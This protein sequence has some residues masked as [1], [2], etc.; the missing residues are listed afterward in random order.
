MSEPFNH[1]T[2]LLPLLSLTQHLY[3]LQ[4][5]VMRKETPLFAFKCVTE[6]GVI[7]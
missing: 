1:A 4:V 2:N 3:G 5:L 6:C 7:L